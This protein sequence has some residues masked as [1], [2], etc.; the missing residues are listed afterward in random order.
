MTRCDIVAAFSFIDD[1]CARTTIIL[2]S[3]HC[4]AKILINYYRLEAAVLAGRERRGHGDC[5]VVKRRR[6]KPNRTTSCF[7][8]VFASQRNCIVCKND[9]NSLKEQRPEP[10]VVPF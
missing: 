9:G 2:T 3:C 6:L 4:V 5:A 8:L 10:E 1:A 7:V